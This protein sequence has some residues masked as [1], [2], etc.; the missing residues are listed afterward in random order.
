M[1]AKWNKESGYLRVSSHPALL[2]TCEKELKKCLGQGV[3]AEAFNPSHREAEPSGCL[4]SVSA[5]TT[6]V[7]SG[8]AMLRKWRKLSNPE[9]CKN[10]F[11]R[12]DHVKAPASSRTWR[13]QPRGSGYRVK[14]TRK[15]LRPAYH[16]YKVKR[17]CWLLVWGVVMNLVERPF[18]GGNQQ[19]TG[20]PSTIR[21]YTPAGRKVSLIAARQTGWLH[22]IKTVQEKEN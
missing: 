4:S 13:L 14:N 17:K 19:H 21:R 8:A 22:G 2:K 3:V 18:G 5:W 9:N 10:V 16:K 20:K 12:G 6:R 1:Y 15:R 11:K 7:S